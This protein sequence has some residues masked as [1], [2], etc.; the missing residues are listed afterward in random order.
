[1]YETKEFLKKKNIEW[2]EYDIAECY[3]I[4]GG[5]P[6]YLSQL[7]NQYSLN[8]NIDELFFKKH[9]A[10]WD[11]F[12]HLYNTL[13]VNG[14]QYIKIVEILSSKKIGLTRYE[15][16]EKSGLS[17]N[18]NLSKILDNL[19]SSGFVR[20]YPFYGNKKKQMLYQ[21][22]DYYTL[23]YFKFLKENYGKDENF[24]SNSYDYPCLGWLYF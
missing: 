5:I 24:W 2:S 10:L 12:E 15:I 1:M 19:V 14:E 23:F 9:S 18:G 11:E 4:M 3:M 17:A 21:L 8:R 20:S 6:F 7:S 16:S 22:C 13:F